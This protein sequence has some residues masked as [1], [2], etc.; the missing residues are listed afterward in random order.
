MNIFLHPLRFLTTLIALCALCASCEMSDC[1]INNIVYGTYGFY[2]Q[3]EEGDE[4][5][6]LLDTLTIRAAG[7]DSILVNRYIKA[8]EVDVPVS[9]TAKADTLILTFTSELGSVAED[10]I[11]IRKENIRHYESPDCPASMFHIVQ[12]V[13][14]TRVFIDSIA[15]I[16]PNI[17]YN[18]SEHFKIYFRT[19]N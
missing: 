8:S 1:P 10:S 15:I 5:I 2:Q 11:I 9:Y 3:G 14:H 17:N 12:G 18:V 6:T 16:N 13:Q 19:G 4:K 7:T